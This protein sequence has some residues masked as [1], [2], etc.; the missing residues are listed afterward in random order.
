MY[1]RFVKNTYF[2]TVKTKFGN[3]CIGFFKTRKLTIYKMTS[4]RKSYAFQSLLK[5]INCYLLKS[6]EILTDSLT[7]Q[8]NINISAD[9]FI[10]YQK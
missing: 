8:Q 3:S 1:L 6:V 9:S 5:N 2:W 7:Y 10:M 4:V